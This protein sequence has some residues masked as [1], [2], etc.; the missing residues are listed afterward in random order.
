MTSLK[1]LANVHEAAMETAE[2]KETLN[3]ALEL[4]KTILARMKQ[5]ASPDFKKEQ[6]A[7]K[8]RKEA[9]EKLITFYVR[10]LARQVIRKKNRVDGNGNTTVLEAN[11]DHVHTFTLMKKDVSVPK[12]RRYLPVKLF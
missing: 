5:S 12:L 9:E 7:D 10:P 2:V 4:Q 1:L 3:H 11:V 6:L 8:R